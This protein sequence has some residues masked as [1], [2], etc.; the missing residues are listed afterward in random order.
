[1]V[2]AASPKFNPLRS[3]SNGLQRSFERALKD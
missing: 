1:M 3:A 2:A